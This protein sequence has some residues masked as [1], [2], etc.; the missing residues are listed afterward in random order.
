[1]EYDHD[2]V[3]DKSIIDLF[4]CLPEFCAIQIKMGENDASKYFFIAKTADIN[5]LQK[6]ENINKFNSLYEIFKKR[7]NIN[8]TKELGGGQEFK[9]GEMI[10][11]TVKIESFAIGKYEFELFIGNFRIEIKDEENEYRILIENRSTGNIK[12]TLNKIGQERAV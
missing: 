2:H 3:Y 6:T 8:I 4:N 10:V 12:L 5:A 1:M 9:I 11:S 7:V